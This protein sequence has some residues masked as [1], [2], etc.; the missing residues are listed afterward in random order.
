MRCFRFRSS[1][2][3][4]PRLFSRF[5]GL[6]PKT[7]RPAADTRRK[8]LV[9]REKK[10]LVPKVLKT[11]KS[12]ILFVFIINF[13][14]RQRAVPIFFMPVERN[15]RDTQMTTRAALVSPKTP[16]RAC[17]PLITKS[18]EKETCG[19]LVHKHKTIRFD[20]VVERPLQSILKS[21]EQ[22]KKRADSP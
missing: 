18:E 3:S 4:D 9:A 12:H 20:E 7:C 1:L 19:Y 8:L 21:A 22:V 2:I 6:R 13:V 16:S 5:F 15:A 17:T 11:I 10:P 14:L